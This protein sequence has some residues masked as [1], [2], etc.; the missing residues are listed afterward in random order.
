MAQP[1]LTDHIVQQL[2]PASGFTEMGE[3]ISCS[4]ES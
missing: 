4:Y 2:Y 3:N 1:E